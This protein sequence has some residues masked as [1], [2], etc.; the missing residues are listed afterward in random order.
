MY[1]AS[2][3][4]CW[5]KLGNI[6][7]LT[8]A[9]PT[10]HVSCLKDRSHLSGAVRSSP[11]PNLLAL[12]P[13]AL[14]ASSPPSWH[15]PPPFLSPQAQARP[16]R[17]R[18]DHA[19]ALAAVPRTGAGPVAA[20]WPGMLAAWGIATP[21]PPPPGAALC[22]T[23]SMPRRATRD[24]LCRREA[25]ASMMRRGPRRLPLY[26]CTS[27]SAP[28][29]PFPLLPRRGFCA[30]SAASSE[31]PLP[32]YFRCPA[33]P[34]QEILCIA[35]LEM[36]ARPLHSALTNPP[37]RQPH[38]RHPTLLTPLFN[39]W[40]VPAAAGARADPEA[41]GASAHFVATAVMPAGA[42][43]C[44]QTSLSMPMSALKPERSKAVCHCTRRC[45]KAVTIVANRQYRKKQENGSLTTYA[46]FVTTGFAARAL[47]YI[48]P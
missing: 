46:A 29:R 17:P 5:L 15:P 25:A 24:G 28:V 31:S 1:I 33:A 26:A 37:P 16:P 30:A 40:A 34:G 35:H 19:A 36:Q 13:C 10:A 18:P 23:P 6:F 11:S 12:P 44:P 20:S 9:F 47:S 22:L 27:C 38:Q 39:A 45:T 4:G 42:S 14:T 7:F 3:P 48:R 2:A 32:L 21:P 43:E 41:V 8:G